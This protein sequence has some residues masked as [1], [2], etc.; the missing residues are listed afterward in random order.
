MLYLPK[1]LAKNYD[2]KTLRTNLLKTTSNI[3][4]APT[5]IEL[6]GLQKNKEVKAISKNYSGQSLFQ[7]ISKNRSIIIMNNNEIAHFKVGISL[8]CNNYH[9]LYRTN[10]VPNKEEVYDIK[11]DK[12]ELKNLIKVLSKKQLYSLLKSFKKYPIC[13][14]YVP[15]VKN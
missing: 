2:V 10:I 9:Y 15:G 14:K 1:A 12:H 13:L 4:I 3:D 11:K 7:P 6:L 8:I 5:I